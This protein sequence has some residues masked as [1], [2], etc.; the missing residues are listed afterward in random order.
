[1]KILILTWRDIKNPSAGGAEIV[2][3]E[4]GK[5]WVTWGH[6][7]TLFTASFPGAADAEVTDGVSIIRRGS[8]W[9]VHYL[10]WRYYRSLSPRTYDV[11]LD[12]LH[13]ISFFTP[14][15]AREPK[16]LLAHEVAR[17]IWFYM[18]PLPV[19]LA[20]YILEP[21]LLRVYRGTSAMTVSRS[22]KDDLIRCGLDGD[23]IDIVPEGI[24]IRPLLT[25][26]R[27]SRPPSIL[28][29]GRITRMK[30]VLHLVRMLSLAQRALPTLE[31]WLAGSGDPRYVRKLLLEAE[32][33]RVSHHVIYH[34]F[35]SDEKKLELMSRAWVLASASTRE[36]WG[37][38]V[39]EANAMGTPA[40]VYDVP[41][42]R[43]S[44]RD[45]ETG[46]VCKSNTPRAMAEEIVNLILDRLR[47]A[48]L[49][50]KA[51]RWSHDFDWNSSA[52]IALASLQ[53]ARREASP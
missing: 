17:E 30:R 34:G 47:Y 28:F 21:L 4:W 39:T 44:V 49:Q 51:W 35:V 14:M 50:E 46:I 20:G 25:L 31:L 15:Y 41:G 38:I 1:M 9:S 52:A 23:R 53:R 13:G 7:V 32:Q 43:D 24:S 18:T 3:H 12:N 22:T 6:E 2:I 8:F 33:C 40:V 42:Y 26:P 29:V 11:I 5:R 16:L 45:G 19:A 37:L 36:G 48:Q 27:K 10:A